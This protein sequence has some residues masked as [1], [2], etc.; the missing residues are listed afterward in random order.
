MGTTREILD[1][2]VSGIVPELKQ[3]AGNSF[4]A[5]IDANVTDSGFEIYGSPYISVLVD[6]RGPTS[7]SPKIGSVS[8]RDRILIWIDQKSIAARP[9]ENG[10][11]ISSESLSWAI[12]KSIHKK[13][14]LLFQRSSKGEGGNNIFDTIITN[15]RLDALANVI[16]DNYRLEVEETILREFKNEIKK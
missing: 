16:G 10:K 7:K 14:T 8:L 12:T 15:D 3:V 1:Q 13:G 4:G 11:T 9:D 5:T 6:G 2:F